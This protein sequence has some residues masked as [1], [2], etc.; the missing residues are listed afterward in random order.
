M[1][2]YIVNLQVVSFV[3]VALT[4]V[5]D[6]ALRKEAILIVGLYLGRLCNEHFLPHLMPSSSNSKVA[7]CREIASCPPK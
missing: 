4:I 6:F 2:L 3:D 1:K 5:A 7:C